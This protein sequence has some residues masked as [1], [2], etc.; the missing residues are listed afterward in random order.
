M[1]HRIRLDRE[2][3]DI[4]LFIIYVSFWYIIYL[5]GVIVCVLVK[6]AVQNE[7]H[8]FLSIR[9]GETRKQ[10]WNHP[11]RNLG[12]DLTKGL[13]RYGHRQNRYPAT[14]VCKF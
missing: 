10:A 2:Y 4:D 5:L 3:V 7:A 8:T 11:S 6:N 9:Y 13:L 14:V 12:P 1:Q